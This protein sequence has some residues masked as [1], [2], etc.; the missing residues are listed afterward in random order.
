[1]PTNFTNPENFQQLSYLR[2]A[3]STL[4]IPIR[5]TVFSCIRHKHYFFP[6]LDF[7]IE[8]DFD[9]DIMDIEFLVLN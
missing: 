9:A 8:I 2:L 1:M 4:L 6:L 3:Q 5:A 7:F